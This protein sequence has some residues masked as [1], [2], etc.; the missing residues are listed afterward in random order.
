MKNIK[1]VE[2]VETS[3]EA[4]HADQYLL[5]TAKQARNRQ[6]PVENPGLSKNGHFVY[7]FSKNLHEFLKRCREIQSIKM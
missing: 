5:S 7:F 3:V 4:N 2:P 6:Q 1:S